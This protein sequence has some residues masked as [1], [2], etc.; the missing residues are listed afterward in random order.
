MTGALFQEKRVFFIMH[1]VCLY[2]AASLQ[3]SVLYVNSNF[4]RNKNSNITR[5]KKWR[6]SLEVDLFTDRRSNDNFLC[7]SM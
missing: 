5:K 2:D 6:K 1:F 3:I 7:I 4:T